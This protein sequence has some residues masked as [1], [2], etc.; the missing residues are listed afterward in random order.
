MSVIAAAE[1]ELGPKA[2]PKA[3]IFISYSRKDMPFAD[4]LEAALRERGFE[5]M[6]DR[7]EIYAFED[8]W[9]RIQSLIVRADTVIFVLSPGRSL[10]MYAP[11]KWSLPLH[12]I[13]ALHRLWCVESTTS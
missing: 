10:P 2:E 12:S 4:R 5:P 13:S 3:K 9:A 11:R 8:W 6:I 7:T 1:S